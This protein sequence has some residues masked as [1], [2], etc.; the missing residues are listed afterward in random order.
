MIKW[1]TKNTEQAKEMYL[2]SNKEPEQLE[3]IAKE[4]G[5]TVQSLRGKLCIMGVYVPI[6]KKAKAGGKTTKS[7]ETKAETLKAVEI[8]LSLPT[9]ELAG[10]EKGNVKSVQ[11]LF[12]ALKTL[13]LVT[14]GKMGLKES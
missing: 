12:E 3:A 11:A 14:H 9:G 5:T 13:S 1:E 10:L 8:M 4:L 6:G 7:A 2:T